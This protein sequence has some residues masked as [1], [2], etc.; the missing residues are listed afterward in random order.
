[1]PLGRLQGR[2]SQAKRFQ[3]WDQC[4]DLKNT[5]AE[6][7]GEKMEKILLCSPIKSKNLILYGVCQINFC[8]SFLMKFW[9]TF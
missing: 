9:Q 4:C 6:K 5:F 8:L 7:N 2:H 3:P 1:V